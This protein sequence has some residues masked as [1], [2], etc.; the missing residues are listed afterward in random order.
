MATKPTLGSF[1]SIDTRAKDAPYS[2]SE[3]TANG[4]KYIRFSQ[5]NGYDCRVNETN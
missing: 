3:I 1:K 2:V 5:Y 4:I